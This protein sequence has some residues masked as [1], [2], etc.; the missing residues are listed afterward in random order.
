MKKYSLGVVA[1]FGLFLLNDASA[2]RYEDIFR[3]LRDNPEVK[4]LAKKAIKDARAF[5][6]ANPAERATSEIPQRIERLQ[7][8]DKARRKVDKASKSIGRKLGIPEDE[9]ITDY[10]RQQ[11]ELQRQQELDRQQAMHRAPTEFPDIFLGSRIV[12]LSDEFFNEKI[13]YFIRCLTARPSDDNSITFFR[14]GQGKLN[15]DVVNRLGRAMRDNP[16][17]YA[18]V[19]VNSTVIDVETARALYQLAHHVLRNNR[20]RYDDGLVGSLV[21]LTQ[22]GLTE[23]DVRRLRQECRNF[24]R[25]V[26]VYGPYGRM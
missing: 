1:L 17:R 5:V 23:W 14:V 7:D 12:W 25:Y 24:D 6:S 22:C 10:E 15:V 3:A 2:S 20:A 19:N 18:R 21:T 8:S 9:L 4:Q 16:N 13:N 26:E 11:R